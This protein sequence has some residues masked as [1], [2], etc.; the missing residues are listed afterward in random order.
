MTLRAGRPSWRPLLPKAVALLGLLASLRD[1]NY[2]GK[3]VLVLGE[4][5]CI[6][7]RM[8]TV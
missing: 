5:M 8:I 6:P 3:D 1:G 4:V 2:I 7:E